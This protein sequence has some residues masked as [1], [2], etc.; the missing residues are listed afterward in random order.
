MLVSTSKNVKMI[1]INGSNTSINSN[2]LEVLLNTEECITG[3]GIYANYIE[4]KCN[5]FIGNIMFNMKTCGLFVKPNSAIIANNQLASSD[6]ATL[7]VL[8]YN[9]EIKDLLDESHIKTIVRE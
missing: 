8:S 7:E 4:N 5:S 3:C 9:Q 2:I 6:Y 1:D